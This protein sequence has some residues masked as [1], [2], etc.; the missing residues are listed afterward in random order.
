MV[1]VSS[2]LLSLPITWSTLHSCALSIFEPFK[3]N[4]FH[5]DNKFK[6]ASPLTCLPSDK[7]QNWNL[8]WVSLKWDMVCDSVILAPEI[9]WYWWVILDWSAS[10]CLIPVEALFGDLS[11][12]SLASHMPVT[13]M[14]LQRVLKSEVWVRFCGGHS[15]LSQDLRSC[16]LH[17]SQE[18]ALFRRHP[19][20]DDGSLKSQN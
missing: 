2:V 15:S 11:N 13:R 18:F 20:S 9:F 14:N 7:L 17:R 10:Y 12:C 16:L 3:A 1:L 4:K 8:Y 19:F 6:R 5:E